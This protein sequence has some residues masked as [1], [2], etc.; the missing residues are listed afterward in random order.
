[1]NL[2]ILKT[3]LTHATSGPWQ[4]NGQ[5]MII[6]S[7]TQKII[8]YCSSDFDVRLIVTL[9]NEAAELLETFENSYTE[10]QCN[11]ICEEYI[12]EIESL[13]DHI[14]DLEDRH[15]REVKELNERIGELEEQK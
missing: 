5:G 4:S 11:E 10:E 15:A 3:E 14:D 9:R 8:G 13:K 6:N 2:E 12:D 7:N 1:M